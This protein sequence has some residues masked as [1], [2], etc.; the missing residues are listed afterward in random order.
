MKS[1]NEQFK[2]IKSN[3]LLLEIKL[4]ETNYKIIK[5]KKENENFIGERK[6]K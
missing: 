3:N 1:N 2:Y 4:F 6:G 5:I